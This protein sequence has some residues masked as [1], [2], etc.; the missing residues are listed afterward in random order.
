MHAKKSLGQHFLRSERALRAI[1]D[2]GDLSEIDT[3]LEIGP[4]E[5]AL[6]QELLDTGARVIAVEK[7]D[8]LFAYLEEK[9]DTETSTGQLELVHGDILKFE[10]DQFNKIVANIPYNITG[11]V[12]RKILS[13][14]HQPERI[15]LLV[16][17]EVAE[18]IVARD[19]KES[20]LSISVKAY[21]IPRYVEKVLAGSFVPAPNVDSAIIAI[22]DI[23]KDF[24]TNFDEERFFEMLRAGFHAKRKKLS[25]N[26]SGLLPKERVEGAFETLELDK[27]TRAEDISINIWQ[28]LAQ[29]LCI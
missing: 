2:A 15:V 1:T 8:N 25:S 28:K 6:T 12:I 26:L 18:R 7:D 24:F 27:N 13:A 23:S 19:G 4:G 11:A 17:K 21:G 22:E 10:S 16:Q 29:L 14:E 9:F 3:V 5:G 20:I